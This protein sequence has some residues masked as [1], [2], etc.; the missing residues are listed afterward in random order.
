MAKRSHAHVHNQN[1]QETTDTTIFPLND[2][3]YIPGNSVYPALD[4]EKV[5]AISTAGFKNVM[6]YGALGNGTHRDDNAIESCFNAAINA[7]VKGVIFPAGHVF[8]LSRLIKIDVPGDLTVYA[9]GATIK[10]DDLTRYSAMQFEGISN[11]YHGTFMWLGG[12]FD[13]NQYNQKYPLNPH[14][15]PYS[16]DSVE[17]HGRFCGIKGKE[18]ALYKDVLCINTV[19]DAIGMD[20]CNI[21]VIAD[22]TAKD[23]AF[24]DY[25]ASGDQSSYFKCTRTGAKAFYCLNVTC[26]G[27]HIGIH[28]STPTKEQGLQTNTLTVLSGCHLIGQASPVHM[29]DCLKTFI[30]NCVMTSDIPNALKHAVHVSNLTNIFWME[31]CTLTNVRVEFNEARD[32]ILNVICNS[33][34]IS[35]ATSG[36]PSIRSFVVNGMYVVNSTFDGR[37]SGDQVEANYARG[38]TFSN[39]PGR[40]AISRADTVADCSFSTG[41]TAINFSGSGKGYNNVYTGVNNTN[42]NTTRTATYLKPF[43][44]NITIKDNNNKY[45]GRLWAGFNSTLNNSNQ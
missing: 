35:E 29:E 41:T 1:A 17:A 31:G 16:G 7:G 11:Q 19:M 23:G 14:G 20:A 5:N 24:I 44:S 6:D 34:F 26:L 43:Q 27:G 13:G 21:A 33:N 39:F 2:Y 37:T 32:M 18:F 9:Y 42:T 10:M 30:Y 15:G 38:C 28:Y 25:A 4:S 3:L 45:I 8:L 36:S 12:T 22:C 40:T